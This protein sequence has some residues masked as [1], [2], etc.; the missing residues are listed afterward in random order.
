M[1]H[2]PPVYLK[3]CRQRE[4]TAGTA[5]PAMD[6]AGHDPPRCSLQLTMDRTRTSPTLRLGCA[7]TVSLS[8]MPLV[9]LA[10]N[11]CSLPPLAAQSPAA[12][13]TRGR[14]CTLA[15]LHDR[16]P[17]SALTEGVAER[18][19]SVSCADPVDC[20]SH[21][22]WPDYPCVVC[23]HSTCQRWVPAVNHL[24]RCLLEHHSFLPCPVAMYM[25]CL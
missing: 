9:Q 16:P 4:L 2:R 1:K 22:G 18:V 7:E 14:P 11:I 15:S 17:L 8:E 25:S 3:S 21:L 12:T 5:P 23:H 19:L 6:L 10:G 24:Q 13:R 20:G